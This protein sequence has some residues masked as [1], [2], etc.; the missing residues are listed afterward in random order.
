MGRWRRN[1]VPN[2]QQGWA[3][4]Q[5]SSFHSQRAIA[6]FVMKISGGGVGLI[7]STYAKRAGLGSWIL[8][9]FLPEVELSTKRVHAAFAIWKCMMPSSW[10]ENWTSNMN[11]PIRQSFHQL[12][13][14]NEIACLNFK[15]KCL[16][17]SVLAWSKLFIN[18][19]KNWQ[20]TVSKF[21]Q[22]GWRKKRKTLFFFECTS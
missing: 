4:C 20:T 10:L 8:T 11:Y 1:C 5:K 6:T 12:L 22:G 13:T 19:L 7:T 15:I 21:F 9:I 17:T 3:I 14:L 2:P 16:R 18:S